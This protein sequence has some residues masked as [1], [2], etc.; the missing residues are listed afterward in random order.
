MLP[1][2]CYLAKQALEMAVAG[3]LWILLLEVHICRSSSPMLHS[4]M[5]VLF[6]LPEQWENK[7]QTE[8]K[9]WVKTAKY[10]PQLI[11]KSTCLQ[12]L[13]FRSFH[14]I[15]VSLLSQVPATAAFHL[16]VS[17][18]KPWLC[19]QWQRRHREGGDNRHVTC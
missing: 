8:K 18:F 13:S 12:A 6:T 5:G 9:Q 1:S 7:K 3:S 17:H 4:G 11:K 14:F 19:H 16:P 10:I 15:H 2:P